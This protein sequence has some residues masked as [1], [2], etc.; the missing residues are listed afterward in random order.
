MNKLPLTIL[1]RSFA[2]EETL[3]AI[4]PHWLE[5]IPT[6]LLI[7][8]GTLSAEGI[9]I[10]LVL[11]HFPFI[12]LSL[13]AI[14]CTLIVGVLGAVFTIAHWFF[15]GYVL[16]ESRI[17]E[18]YSLPLLMHMTNGILLNQVRCT[19]ID[20][21]KNG[22]LHHLFNIGDITITFDRPTRQEEFVLRHI[23]MPEEVSLSLSTILDTRPTSKDLHPLW[24][25]ASSRAP[26]VLFVNDLFPQAATT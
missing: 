13:L 26:Q 1:P 18:F 21:A 19:E 4:R 5:F 11:P 16:T 20:F 24:K 3:L 2:G 17:M 6:L 23:S 15:H 14:V 12:Y 22:L 7:I 10:M 25:K 8:L 9:I